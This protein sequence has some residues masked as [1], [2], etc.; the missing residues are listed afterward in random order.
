[1]GFQLGMAK[2]V[3]IC[4]ACA[5]KYPGGIIFPQFFA[6]APLAQA[7]AAILPINASIVPV[8]VM[9]TM[10]ATQ[11]SVTRTPLATALILSLT[12][13]SATELSVMLPACLVSA[14]L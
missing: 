7:A 9:C 14:Y 11:A 10:A 8:V 2:L 6:S 12:A 4:L 3:A 5:G 1:M 13:A